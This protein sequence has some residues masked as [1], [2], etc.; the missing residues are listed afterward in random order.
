M[1]DV[2]GSRTEQDIFG[3]DVEF[4][5]YG[6]IDEPDGLFLDSLAVTVSLEGISV[7]R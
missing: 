1:Y 4:P 3:S 5:V 6:F 7:A 2:S